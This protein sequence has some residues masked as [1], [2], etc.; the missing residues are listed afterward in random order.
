AL[1]AAAGRDLLLAPGVAG[2]QLDHGLADAV[3][4]GAQL[5]EHLGRDAFSLTDQPEQDVLGAD[6]VVTELE[7]LAERQLQDLLGARRERDV[8]R[9]RRLTLADDLLDLLTHGVEV[10][11]EAVERLGGNAFALVDQTEEDVLGPDVVVVE[12]PRFF[13]REDHDPSGAIRE[14]L[15]H[16]TRPSDRSPRLLPSGIRGATSSPRGTSGAEVVAP[17]P[18]HQRV[19][20]W[21]SERLEPRSP[22]SRPFPTLWFPFGC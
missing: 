4:V 22:C 11:V 3:E 18:V 10:D 14:P 12:H 13:L 20:P 7:R 15:E 6:V 9:R 21:P 5:L 16:L 19:Y 2:E 17:A 1:A 8:T